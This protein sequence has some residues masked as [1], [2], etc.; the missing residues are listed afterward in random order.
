MVLIGI[1]GSILI[2]QAEETL[3]VSEHTRLLRTVEKLTGDYYRRVHLF[4]NVVRNKIIQGDM[5]AVQDEFDFAPFLF[6]VM[7]MDAYGHLNIYTVAN[8]S[9]KSCNL[10]LT[11]HHCSHR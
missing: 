6:T 2:Y 1:V 9:Q 3:L 5:A 10:I 8:R 7:Q 4:F 11:S